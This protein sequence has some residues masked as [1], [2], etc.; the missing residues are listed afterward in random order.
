VTFE[1]YGLLAILLIGIGAQI[2]LI[3]INGRS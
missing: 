1:Y 3:F 2:A